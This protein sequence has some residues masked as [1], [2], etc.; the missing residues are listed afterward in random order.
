MRLFIGKTSNTFFNPLIIEQDTYI[1]TR[2]FEIDGSIVEDTR[3][4]VNGMVEI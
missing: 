2:I 4:G 1:Y 3:F